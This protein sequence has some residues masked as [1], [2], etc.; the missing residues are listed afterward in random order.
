MRRGT[1]LSRAMAVA[2]RIPDA[3][4]VIGLDK[5]DSG[6]AHAWVE[7]NGNPLMP[8][9]ARDHVMARL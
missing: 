3:T 8:S 4:V 7:V 1:C 2:A 9:E 6:F 5:S